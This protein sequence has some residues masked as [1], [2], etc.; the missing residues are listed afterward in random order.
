MIGLR[1]LTTQGIEKFE[2]YLLVL[3][4]NNK[5]RPPNLNLE[6]FSKEVPYEYLAYIDETKQFESRMELGSYL[7]HRFSLKGIKRDTVILHDPV[8][9]NNVWSWLA[10][11][12]MEQFVNF[13]DGLYV[14]PVR[15]RFFGGSEWNRFYRHF[16]AAPY[17]IYSLHGEE[18][19]KLFLDCD[20]SIHNDFLEQIASRQWIINSDTLVQLAHLLYWNK[21]KENPKRGARGKGGGTVRRYGK[22]INQLRRTYDIHNMDIHELLKLLPSEFENWTERT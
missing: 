19:S 14:V 16:V 2:T 22:V 21:D 1:E 10:Y 5:F 15:T 9:W 20:P 13:K 18:N 17:Y 11:I 6:Q 8:L 3:A 4:N 7:S 12:W